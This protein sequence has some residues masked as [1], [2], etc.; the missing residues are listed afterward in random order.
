MPINLNDPVQG[1]AAEDEWVAV[2]TVLIYVQ[3]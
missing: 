1:E 3:H 2:K